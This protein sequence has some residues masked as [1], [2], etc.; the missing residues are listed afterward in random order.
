VGAGLDLAAE[1]VSV[2]FEGGGGGGGVGDIGCMACCW[3]EFW[4]G[5]GDTCCF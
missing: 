1:F 3:T 2:E 4:V 5:V